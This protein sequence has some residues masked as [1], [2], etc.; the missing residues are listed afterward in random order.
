MN[1]D[2]KDA[3]ESKDRSDNGSLPDD[4]SMHLLM[5]FLKWSTQ[6]LK[7][8]VPMLMNRYFMEESLVHEMLYSRDIGEVPPSNWIDYKLDSGYY[9][10]DARTVV[11]LREGRP[12]PVRMPYAEVINF[13]KDRKARIRV[14][15]RIIPYE[16]PH[17][18]QART[19]QNMH[20][21]C[22]EKDRTF[23]G[24]VL[25]LKSLRKNSRNSQWHAIL[26]RARYFDQVR[27]NL[28]L[29]A[30]LPPPGE[31][32]LRL[33]DMGPGNS[34]PTFEESLMV[35]S[36]GVSAVCYFIGRNR[37]KQFF[38]KVRQSA[39]GVFEDMLATTSGVV[40]PP[41]LPED[42]ASESDAPQHQVEPLKDLN[43]YATREMIREF[44]R[45]TG[46]SEDH[47]LDIQPL[48]FVRELTRG[49]KPQFFFLI[50]I[51]PIK[52][53]A[54]KRRFRQSLEGLDEFHDNWKSDLSAHK[55]PLSPEF[56]CN[57]V[58][59]LEHLQTVERKQASPLVLD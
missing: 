8:L 16:M 20:K 13:T 34:L 4:A 41:M 11:F 54:F 51:K 18:L 47:I 17:A 37:R 55:Q 48:A 3:N 57:L 43:H 12:K 6:K 38:M 29:D 49:G 56:A 22:D 28:T 14:R 15:A 7:G 45:E 33:Q 27:T 19:Q 23:N 58:Y 1:L 42:A 40:E 26:E 10:Q 44:T 30:T 52:E 53:L 2:Q 46:L 32:T 21:F 50:E 9:P 39:D 59:A 35:N 5:R 36:I 31:K 25:R 24:P